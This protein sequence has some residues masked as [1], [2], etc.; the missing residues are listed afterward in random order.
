MVGEKR[1]LHKWELLRTQ[2]ME[3]LNELREL[4]EKRK[5]HW[6][7]FVIQYGGTSHLIPDLQYQT[8]LS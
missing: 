4:G 7:I 5:E 6:S 3:D 8:I 1:L 2:R